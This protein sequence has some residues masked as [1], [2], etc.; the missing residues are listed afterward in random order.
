MSLTPGR[1][2]NP[3]YRPDIDGLR[4]LAVIAVILF[5][6]GVPGFE[7]G[8]VG[9]DIFFVISGYLITQLLEVSREESVGRTLSAFYLRRM[10][11][12]LP[13]LLVTCLVTSI[14]AVA[15]FTPD[16]LV[17]VG[18]Y[19]AATPV[20]LSNVATW[21]QRN[22]YFAPD[23]RELPLTHL[24]SISVEEQFYLFY[25]LLLIAIIRYPL[26]HRRLTLAVLAVVSLALCVW[27]SHYKPRANYFFAPT[28]AW[29]LLLGATLAIGGT[30]RIGKRIA[31]EGL[32]VAGLLGIVIVVYRYTAETPYPGTAAMLPCLATAMLLATGSSPR[33]ALVNRIL[34]WPP[35]VFIGLISYSLYL[36][37]QPLLAFVN[38]YRIAP[39]TP[40][41][42]TVPLAATLV[43]AAASW[44]FIERPVRTRMLM[45]STRALLVSVGVGSACI[46]LA[47]LTLWY[48]DGFPNRFPPEARGLIVSRYGTPDRVSCVEEVPLEQVRAGRVCNYGPG[49]SAPKVL[50]WGDSYAMA[51]MPAVKALAQEHGMHTYFVAKYN[52]LPLFAP[53]GATRLDAATD[54][55]GCATFNAAVVEAIARVEPELII[56]GGAWVATE[57]PPHVHDI[58]VGIE[59][60]VIRLG[61][62]AHST[63][64]VLAVP[65]L[66]YAVSHALLVARRRHIPDDFLRLSRADAL[67][68]HWEMEHGLRAIAQR[69]G[70]KVVDPKDALCP[71]DSCLY[72]SDGQSLYFDDS[73]LSV[74]GALYAARTLEPCFTLDGH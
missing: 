29:E 27:A 34:S 44:R 13:A 42:T 24:W 58:A 37:H 12:I 72:K 32:A 49:G 68:Q 59:Q 14:V 22:G 19:L 3:A 50:V 64:V 70:L 47:G 8:Y 46:L 21:S 38:Y 5:H 67:A 4:A 48:S 16:E 66:K 71:A 17:N 10:R 33:P 54:P 63:C 25:P 55:Y 57:P 74:Y 69:G 28:R 31:A 65:K 56:L 73:H 7:G 9:V 2:H 15:L 62:H 60:A 30:P 11:R 6:S 40:G 20:M 18:K 61:D 51:L 36:W 39:L 43:V 23:I 26:S 53:P 41:A 35:L 45:K 1:S 52:C